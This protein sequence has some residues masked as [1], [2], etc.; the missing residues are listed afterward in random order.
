M[1]ACAATVPIAIPLAIFGSDVPVR[2]DCCSSRP[3]EAATA[4]IAAEA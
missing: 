1:K 2:A 3:N 4:L